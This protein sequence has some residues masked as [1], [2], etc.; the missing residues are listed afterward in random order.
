MQNTNEKICPICKTTLVSSGR[1][2]FLDELLAMWKPVE[3]AH[4][5][6]EELKTQSNY[7]QLHICPTCKLGI[8]LPQIIGTPNFY[9]ELQGETS[10]AYYVDEK[11]DFDT[12][13]NDAKTA[14]AVIEIGCGPGVFL[15][16]ASH[17]VNQAIGIEYNVHALKM[18]RKKGL[19]VFNVE[20]DLSK[21][22][23]QFDIAFS[24]HVLEHVSDPV[25]F[26]QAM[27]SWVKP[28][29]KIG[30]SVPN[31]DGPIKYINPC[32]SNM[33]P[34]HATRWTLETFQALADRLGLKIERVEF[35][36]LIVR[37]YYYYSTYAI[38]YWFPAKYWPKRLVLRLQHTAN[39]L[40]G[41]LFKILNKF[42][43]KEFGLLK[44]QSIYV[45]LSKQERR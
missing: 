17:Y 43:K 9:V 33:P 14:K 31:M 37:D 12:A 2:F 29:G 18:A 5:T 25:A 38:D 3:F 19:S 20:D 7:T 1:T 15:D 39:Y 13:L 21:L 41:L 40:F 35:E 32:V 4:V 8:F 45:L 27:L 22:K 44:G 24:F 26:I 10:D 11:W 30:I 6:V 36:P 34:H 16:R 28:N 42:N 23:G